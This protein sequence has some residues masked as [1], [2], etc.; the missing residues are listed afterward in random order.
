MM[1]TPEQIKQDFHEEA[2][3]VWK[4]YPHPEVEVDIRKRTNES[5]PIMSI[6]AGHKS[7]KSKAIGR[8]LLKITKNKIILYVTDYAL[9]LPDDKYRGLLRHEAIHIGYPRHDSQFKDVA[10]IV[11][12]PLT[13]H[14]MDDVEP[15]IYIQFQPKRGA[16]YKTYKTMPYKREEDLRLAQQ[17]MH[18]ICKEKRIRG[19]VMVKR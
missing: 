3:K 9:S 2:A 10:R 14:E 5:I 4:N 11:N 19:R 1:K 6:R 13:E 18:N 7:Y 12:A 16:R 17:E 15:E 8:T